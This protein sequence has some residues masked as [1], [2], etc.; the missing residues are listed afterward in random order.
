MI[1]QP[2]PNT[3]EFQELIPGIKPPRVP[4]LIP[5]LEKIPLLPGWIIRDPEGNIINAGIRI[6]VL[7]W[8]TAQPPDEQPEHPVMPILPDI[9]IRE[10]VEGDSCDTEGTQH[11]DLRCLRGTWR[12]A[13]G[14]LEEEEMEL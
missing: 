14:A 8:E 2:L 11:G 10:P 12:L 9:P 1:E 3:I 6:P 13:V 7:T 4:I 5:G